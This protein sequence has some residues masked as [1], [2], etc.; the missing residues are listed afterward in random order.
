MCTDAHCACVAWL[1]VCAT[2]DN[3]ASVNKLIREVGYRHPPDTKFMFGFAE[4][5]LFVLACHFAFSQKSIFSK[6]TVGILSSTQY[7]VFLGEYVMSM[8]QLLRRLMD[9]LL[10]KSSCKNDSAS[11][12]KKVSNLVYFLLKNLHNMHYTGNNWPLWDF[13]EM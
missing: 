6:I 2:S 5:Q 1:V 13:N 12:P 9:I 4:T 8:Q 7:A 10:E 3:L 11:D